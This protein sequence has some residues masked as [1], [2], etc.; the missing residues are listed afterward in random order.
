VALVTAFIY[1][2][3]HPELTWQQA[4]LTTGVIF[5]LFQI[6]PIS[7]G[8]IA[9]GIYTSALILREKNFKDYRIAFGLS[10]FKYIGYLAFPIQMAYRYPD[11]AR[12]MAGH[13]ATSAVHIVPV[14]GEKG[15]W[16][17]HF[18]FDAFYNF[19][20]TIRRRIKLRAEARAGRKPRTAHALPLVLAGTALLAA[21]DFAVFKAKGT[22]P[23]LKSVWWLALWAPLFGSAIISRLAGGA[24]LGRRI[25]LGTIGGGLQ[26]LLYALA[27]TFLPPIYATTAA[28]APALTA[29]PLAIKVL[30]HVFLF[31]L[32]ALVGAILAETRRVR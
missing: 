12:F 28:S 27:N 5:A 32:V 22:V 10:F 6:I 7:P 4:S 15:A 3:L 19:P 14:F 17:E 9:R 29:G 23:V 11:L 18:V 20:L 21:L 30:W 2:R 16:L 1:V 13:W 8:S 31:T 26:G 24:K 25:M